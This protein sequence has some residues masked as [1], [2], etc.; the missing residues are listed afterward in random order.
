MDLSEAN[1][2][3]ALRTHDEGVHQAIAVARNLL[4]VGGTGVGVAPPGGPLPKVDT[5]GIYA[6]AASAEEAQRMVAD[7]VS[8]LEGV[9]V[10][11]GV[12]PFSAE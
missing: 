6:K 4:L 2:R 3:V 8:G 9:A 7:A 12:Q 5:W 11:V 10:V 1:Y